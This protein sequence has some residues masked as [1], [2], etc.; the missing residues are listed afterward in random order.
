MAKPA[1]RSVV[2]Q[3]LTVRVKRGGE[4]VEVPHWFNRPAEDWDCYDSF[5]TFLGRVWD[6]LGL[7]APTRAQLEIAHRLQYGFDS[8]EATTLPAAEQL[9]RI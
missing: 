6:H 8:H 9:D 4:L 1:S 3:P 2:L 7:P 5:A